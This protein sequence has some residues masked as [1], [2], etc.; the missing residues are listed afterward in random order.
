MIDYVCEPLRRAVEDEHP[1]VRKTAALSIGK[2][3]GAS[4]EVAGENGLGEC[5]MSMLKNEPNV[6]VLGNVVA[7]V[8]DL[9]G[10][11]LA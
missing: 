2:V 10:R 6:A 5:L 9:L 3:F 11:G 8:I 1:Y 4:L 7:V